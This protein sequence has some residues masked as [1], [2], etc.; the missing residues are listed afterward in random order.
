MYC[1]MYPPFQIRAWRR[2]IHGTWDKWVCSSLFYMYINKYDYV[3]MYRHTQTTHI[4]ISYVN[5]YIYTHTHHTRLNSNID[6]EKTSFSQGFSPYIFHIS[7]FQGTRR[8]VGEDRAAVI[9]GCL[10]GN[11]GMGLEDAAEIDL[12]TI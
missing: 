3:H 2:F 10:I 12:T 11:D 8:R 1:N 5:I 4:H 9:D 7:D 6:V